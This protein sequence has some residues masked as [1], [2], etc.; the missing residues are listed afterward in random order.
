MGDNEDSNYAVVDL[1][2]N[3]RLLRTIQRDME[4]ISGDKDYSRGF[5]DCFDTVKDRLEL[6]FNCE[7]DP[8]NDCC[9]RFEDKINDF[10]K[11]LGGE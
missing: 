9:G 5:K 1:N 4:F 7:I 11:E 3:R 6:I 2:K 8:P 10:L